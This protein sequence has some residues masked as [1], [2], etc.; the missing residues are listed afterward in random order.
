MLSYSMK[1]FILMNDFYFY[2]EETY[3]QFQQLKDSQNA[4]YH[5]KNLFGLVGK[6]AYFL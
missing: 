1:T 4:I 6:N 2:Q 3:L 5:G